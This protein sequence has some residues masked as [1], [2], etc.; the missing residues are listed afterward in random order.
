MHRR[1]ALR[2]G[3]GALAVG[4]A[5]CLASEAPG[6][7][8]PSESPSPSPSPTPTGTPVEIAD[9]ADQPDV[10]VEYAVEMAEPRATDEHPARPRVTLTNP[11]DS[12]VVLGE[13]REVQCYYVSS[14]GRTLY[15]APVGDGE[16]DYP[17]NPG[18]W[19][20]TE[21]VAT[22][23]YY[24]TLSVGA[25]EEVTAESFVFGHQDLPAGTCLPEGDHQV[26]IEGRAGDS[27]GEVTDDGATR[28]EWGFTLQVG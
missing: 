10:P 16:V 2:I 8:S 26:R 13:E 19:Q 28:F 17:V 23:A 22:D 25:G 21:G 9:R 1:Q 14:D 15:L 7:P 24:G 11:T 20:L 5:G 3:A 4:M 12:E 6:D 27:P 18:C